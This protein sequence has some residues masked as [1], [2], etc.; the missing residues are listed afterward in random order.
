MTVCAEYGIILE[1]QSDGGYR[2]PYPI[3][4]LDKTQILR[5]LSPSVREHDITELS[6]LDE[7]DS[8]NAWLLR[9]MPRPGFHACLAEYQRAGRGRQGRRWLSPPGSGI[10]LSV[11][12]QSQTQHIAGLNL[13]VAC[14]LADLLKHHAGHQPRA[15]IKIKW[16][17][18]LYWQGKKLAGLLVEAKVTPH[19]GM[20]VVVGV[21]LNV[22]LATKPD[23]QR[24]DLSTIYT[25]TP[26]RNALAG[27]LIQR[28]IENIKRFSDEGLTPFLSQWREYDMLFDQPVNILRGQERQHGIARGIDEAGFLQVEIDGRLQTVHDGEVS[29]RLHG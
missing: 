25:A 18:D 8:S 28:V 17:N 15:P 9:Q 27:A 1:Q 2:L 7:T 10:C 14:G 19:Q 24:C 20:T 29:V 16:P 26:S 12:Y 21:G 13:A 23:D 11:A 4:W 3:E 5:A 6:V 22:H